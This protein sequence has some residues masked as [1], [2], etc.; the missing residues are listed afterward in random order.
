MVLL[1]NAVPA[2]DQSLATID[3]AAPRN[4]AEK[5]ALLREAAL[6]ITSQAGQLANPDARIT[7]EEGACS[8]LLN[9]YAESRWGLRTADSTRFIR[10]FWEVCLPSN[11]WN[12]QQ[13]SVEET[14]Q[15]SGREHVVLWEHGAGELKAFAEAGLASIQGGDAWGKQGVCIG[16]MRHLPA[17]RYTGEI[18]DNNCAALLCLPIFA[19]Y[20]RS[21]PSVLPPILTP[22]CEESTKSST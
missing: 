4:V 19:I 6:Q 5:A 7:L 2:T 16:L 10:C 17:T 21:G 1:S 20:Q 11:R 22:P 9:D 8:G 14:Q 15:F 18:F 3:A 13:S 12:Y